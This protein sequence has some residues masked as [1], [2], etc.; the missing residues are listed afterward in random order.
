ML[1]DVGWIIMI[2]SCAK[3]R[4][5]LTVS[6]FESNRLQLLIGIATISV[7]IGLIPETGVLRGS[8]YRDPKNQ[9]R[10]RSAQGVPI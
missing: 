10:D 7:R 3:A 1:F 6:L 2:Y 5:E 4:I 8:L 9:T